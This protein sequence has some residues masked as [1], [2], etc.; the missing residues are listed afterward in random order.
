MATKSKKR[1]TRDT[2]RSN[3]IRIC[4]LPSFDRNPV[5]ELSSNHWF[6]NIG[7]IIHIDIQNNYH[8]AEIRFSSQK[9][10]QSALRR[11]HQYNASKSKPQRKL[12]ANYTQTTIKTKSPSSPLST[13]KEY[14]SLQRQL[15]ALSSDHTKLKQKNKL[16]HQIIKSLQTNLHRHYDE[17]HDGLVTKNKELHDLQLEHKELYDDNQYL[18]KQQRNLETE[19]TQ[20]SEKI[21]SIQMENTQLKK[22]TTILKSDNNILTNQKDNLQQRIKTIQTNYATMQQRIIHERQRM[23]S[24]RE[25]LM[26]QSQMYKQTMEWYARLNQE[27]LRELNEKRAI[28]PIVWSP[29]PP[30]LTAEPVSQAVNELRTSLRVRNIGFNDLYQM[31]QNDLRAIG[32]TS[33]KDVTLLLSEI[34]KLRLSNQAIKAEDKEVETAIEGG[35]DV[36]ME[37]GPS[38]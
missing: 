2:K 6:G 32:I 25:H 28:D 26:K 24:E 21:K 19:A 9:D 36:R 31:D 33:W 14:Q 3:A 38:T 11:V 1:T 12:Q 13:L 23:L 22:I 27:Y 37:G 34:Q 4:G 18:R 7:K 17:T 30:S 5:Q 10:A 20:M 29:S 35:I 8:D 16:L 15:H